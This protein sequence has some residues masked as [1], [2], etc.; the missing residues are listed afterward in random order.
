MRLLDLQAVEGWLNNYTTKPTWAPLFPLC[1]TVKQRKYTH[2]SEFL[3]CNVNILD[4]GKGLG[5]LSAPSHIQ[6]W[7]TVFEVP[8]LAPLLKHSQKHLVP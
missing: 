3:I 5:C 7:S 8:T 6:F 4:H 2:C 1:C